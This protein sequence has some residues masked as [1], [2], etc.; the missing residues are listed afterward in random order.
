ML[1][2]K[3]NFFIIE[4]PVSNSPYELELS[5]WWKLVIRQGRECSTD[6]MT[7]GVVRCI[8]TCIKDGLCVLARWLSLLCIQM[9]TFLL[10]SSSQYRL[11]NYSTPDL[12]TRTI[13]C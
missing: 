4:H 9:V 13:H 8:S 1:L 2:D 5:S 3:M 6:S 12:S 7:F 11:K 10:C